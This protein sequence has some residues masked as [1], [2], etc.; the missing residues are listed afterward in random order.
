MVLIVTGQP[1]RIADRVLG[2]MHR[3]VTGLHGQGMY[4]GAAREVLMVVLTVTEVEQLKAIIR[5]E[6]PDALV[7][8]SPAQQ[9]LGREFEPL[10]EVD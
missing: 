1:R 3:G 2:E 5:A 7:I 4:T 6:D 10:A 8:V 9:V